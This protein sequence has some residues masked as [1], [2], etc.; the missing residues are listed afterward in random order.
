MPS[1]AEESGDFID[2]DLRALG[3][4]A[5]AG[6]GGLQFFEDAGNDDWF[7]GADV[8]DETFAIGRI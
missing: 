8:I 5:D 6:D 4:E 2:I 7:D 3:T 1:T